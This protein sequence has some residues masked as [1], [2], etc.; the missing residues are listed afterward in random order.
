MQNWKDLYLEHANMISAKTDAIE[1]IDLWHNQ[2]NFLE[3]EHPF[4][5]PAVFLSYRTLQTNDVGQKVQNVNLQ[6]DIYLFYETFA[7]TYK[8]SFNQESA[9]VFIDLMDEINNVFHGS[10]GENF[11]SMR[12]TG[13]APMDTG[14]AGNLYRMSYTCQLMDYS[15]T[16][17]YDEHELDEIK[18][19]KSEQPYLLD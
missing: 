11:S 6:V 14:N 2:V 7:D 19:E 3:T 10:A 1:W 9:L 13:F 15:A 16:K 5:T 18:I 12:R 8:D 17:D 4:P